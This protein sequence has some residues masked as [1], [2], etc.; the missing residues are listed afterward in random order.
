MDLLTK[1]SRHLGTL[2]PNWAWLTRHLVWSLPMTEGAGFGADS[3]AQ[4]V[5][6]E[7]RGLPTRF[8]P[9]GPERLTWAAFEH[10]IGYRLINGNGLIGGSPFVSMLQYAPQVRTTAFADTNEITTAAVFRYDGSHSTALKTIV[11]ANNIIMSIFPANSTAHLLNMTVGA[12]N[13]NVALPNGFWFDGQIH[14]AAISYSPAR[15][16]QF[17]FYLD[18]R[19]AG[20]FIASSSNPVPSWG[21]TRVGGSVSSDKE[22]KGFNGILSQVLLLNKAWNDGEARAWMRDPYGYLRPYMPIVRRVTVQEGVTPPAPLDPCDW[23]DTKPPPDWQAANPGQDWASARP[24]PDW[25]DD[26]AQPDWASPRTS[27][28]WFDPQDC[29]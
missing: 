6:T 24:E 4:F 26:K 29:D 18:G 27:R 1:P 12:F 5:R 16:P 2:N 13:R 19:L 23:F 11:R 7:N 22:G 10:G 28:D 3:P 25:F 15:V 14:R 21:F 20:V 17:K 9:E 8:D